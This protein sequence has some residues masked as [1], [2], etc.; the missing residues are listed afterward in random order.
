MSVAKVI[1]LTASSPDSL[2]TPL[3]A[4][5][6]NARFVSSRL[7]RPSTF[8]PDGAYAVQPTTNELISVF[9]GRRE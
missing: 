2:T 9:C 5:V 4:K 7:V 6:S 8:S 1:E 3:Y